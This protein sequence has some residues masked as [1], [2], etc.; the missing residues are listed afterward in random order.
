MSKSSEQ[1]LFEPVRYGE[2]AR[3]G[4]SF[5]RGLCCRFMILLGIITVGF[6]TF[7]LQKGARAVWRD[8]NFLHGD[9]I[10]KQED[11]FNGN[12]KEISDIKPH[13]SFVTPLIKSTDRFGIRA[14]VWLDVTQHLSQ[15]LTLPKDLKLITYHTDRNTTRTEAILYSD[16][17][18]DSVSAIDKHD[19]F[20]NVP[21]SI[22]IDPLYTQDLGPSTLRMTYAAVPNEE[23]EKRLGLP[24]MFQS[25]IPFSSSILPRTINSTR[26]EAGCDRS[27]DNKTDPNLYSH[28]VSSLQQALEF[29]GASMSLLDLRLTQKSII[30]NCTYEENFLKGPNFPSFLDNAPTHKS[31]TNKTVFDKSG[32]RLILGENCTILSP[33]VRTQSRVY[34]I[35]HDHSLNFIPFAS[36]QE[37][38][39]TAMVS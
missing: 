37:K 26:I 33:Y 1:V 11:V 15:G 27:L 28:N 24:V 35:P 20:A 6:I 38:V 14:T 34:M 3:R 7:F 17:V 23:T 36:R 18:F 4:R 10:V 29:N 32:R 25:F 13:F 39:K 22:P 31:F 12:S 16:I 9:L 5:K 21:I 2:N 30:P 8:L 19:S